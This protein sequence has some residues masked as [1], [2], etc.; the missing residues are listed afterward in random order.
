MR[1]KR[2]ILVE[3]NARMRTLVSASLCVACKARGD[4]DVLSPDDSSTAPPTK[5]FMLHRGL[6]NNDLFTSAA[7]LNDA[8]LAQ[9]AA[10]TFSLALYNAL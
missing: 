6:P 7:P 2:G 3:L 8:D 1:L 5:K 10:G 4:Q 9:L